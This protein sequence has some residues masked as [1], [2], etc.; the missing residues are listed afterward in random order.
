MNAENRLFF[1][2]YYLLVFP[3]ME[4]AQPTAT[5]P[6]C[7]YTHITSASS[8][9]STSAAYWSK[10][11]NCEVRFLQKDELFLPMEP[12]VLKGSK[13]NGFVPIRI[14]SATG[15]VGYILFCEWHKIT[16]W[17]GAKK[18]SSNEQD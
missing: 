18:E 4:T 7:W 1:S 2:P 14:I 8:T 13:T 11:L 9:A 6:G 5:P 16:E 3:T 12:L 15:I 10:Q 17:S